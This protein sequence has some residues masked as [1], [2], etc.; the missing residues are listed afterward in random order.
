MC[1]D[2]GF[3]LTIRLLGVQAPV[4]FLVGVQHKT[5]DIAAACGA[6]VHVNVLEGTVTVCP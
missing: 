4:P 5:A 6:L 3:G 2:V 1:S